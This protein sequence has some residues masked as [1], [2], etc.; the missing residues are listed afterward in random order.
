MGRGIPSD[1]KTLALGLRGSSVLDINVGINRPGISDRH[2][3]YFPEP[4]FVFYRVG[5]PMNFSPFVCP[6][7]C[8]SMYIEVAFNHESPMN[9][10]QTVQTALDQL[11][12]LGFMNRSDQPVSLHVRKIPDA[13]PVYDRHRRKAV[14]ELLSFL[15]QRDIHSLGRYGAWEYSAMED[16]ILQGRQ[17]AEKL[18]MSDSTRLAPVYSTSGGRL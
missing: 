3:I 7:D 6:P 10:E 12:Y 4:S 17:I 14:P 1:A 2:W 15:G 16:A 13:Y 18:T 9:V 11:R 8:S 5:F